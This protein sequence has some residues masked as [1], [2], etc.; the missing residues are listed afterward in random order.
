MKR[1]RILYSGQVQGVG[2]RLAS[3]RTALSLGLK[4]RVE[5]LNDGRVEV[6]C[7]G[8]E[9]L[10]K[11]FIG[12]IGMIFGMYIRNAD[13]EWSEATGEFDGFDIL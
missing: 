5:N 10:L 9:R 8:E 2:F 13:M 12:K 6:V 11:E 4:G 7:E 1:V 3:E